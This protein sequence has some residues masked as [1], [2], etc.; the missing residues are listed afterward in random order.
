LAASMASLVASLGRG[1]ITGKFLDEKRRVLIRV[2]F[3][4]GDW[5][6][7]VPAGNSGC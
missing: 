1:S 2:A 7:M 3:L 5:K 4:K 6:N